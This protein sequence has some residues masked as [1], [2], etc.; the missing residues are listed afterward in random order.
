MKRVV[1]VS[2]GSSARDKS[3]DAEFFGEQFRIERVG[4]DGSF[5]KYIAKLEEL[6]GNVDAIGIGGL[7]VY[8][9][10]NGRRYAFREAKR[11]VS[12][13][14]KTPW[15]DGSGLK[16]TLERETV[17]RLQADGTV[18]F[19]GKKVLMVAG[20]DRFGMAEALHEAGA[21]L[22]MGDLM[23]TLGLPVVIRQWS[24][25]QLIAKMLLPIVVQAPFKLLYPTG[26]K[27]DTITPKYPRWYEWA[28]VIAGDF[29]F[30][31]RY[32]PERMDGKVILTNT[33]RKADRQQLVDR[34]V[35]T[36][37]TTTP[38]FGGES[39]GTNVMEG[40]LVTAAG[41]RPEEMTPESYMEMLG[42]L[43]WSPNVDRLG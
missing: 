8:L 33:T 1:S 19:R 37:V 13:L 5:D 29:L 32:M 17:R 28:D 15:V 14:H 21:D 31:R 16:N 35:A 42:R 25:F 22:A 4:V 7:D 18:D 6:D 36:L 12:H 20:V 27:Q 11:L 9:W 2:L 39:F 24:S 41:K 40:V 3:Q 30:I 26:E 38:S 34:G 23:F 43:N 10:A